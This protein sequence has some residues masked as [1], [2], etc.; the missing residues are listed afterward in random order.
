[1]ALTAPASSKNYT[2][3]PRLFPHLWLSPSETG[4]VAPGGGVASMELRRAWRDFR[5]ALRLRS[6]LG[7]SEAAPVL[8]LNLLAPLPLPRVGPGS[9]L[10]ILS[11]VT[12]FSSSAS[13]SLDFSST[14]TFLGGS[15][16]EHCSDKIKTILYHQV[17]RNF[18]LKHT[19]NVACKCTG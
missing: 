6:T 11:G 19:I 16:M 2:P 1:M 17:K 8:L 15:R 5:S 10:P 18:V 13:G 4:V 9:S 14:T 3:T 12:D 7:A